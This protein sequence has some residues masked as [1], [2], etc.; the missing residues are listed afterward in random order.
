MSN[1][2]LYNSSDHWWLRTWKWWFTIRSTDPTILFREEALRVLLIVIPLLRLLAL[3]DAYFNPPIRI[4]FP[5]PV[6]VAF[7]FLPLFVSFIALNRQ[8]VELSGLAFLA[9]WYL[10]DLTS[11]PTEGYWYPNFQISLIIQVVLAN[12]LL[13]TRWILPFVFFQLVTVLGFGAWL[14]ANWY[15]PPFLAT[16]IPFTDFG[17]TMVRLVMQ[18]ITIVLIVRFLRTEMEKYLKLQQAAIGRLQDQIHERQLAE[19]SLRQAE[20][21][22]RRLVEQSSEGI[23]LLDEQGKVIEYNRQAEELTGFKRDQVIGTMG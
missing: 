7:A 11:I 18:E 16:G 15:H 3:I 2:P 17:S 21:K 8:R 22:F 10:V 20:A 5:F 9:H 13:S 12:L 19:Q 6:I 4:F 14:D 1:K 23:V